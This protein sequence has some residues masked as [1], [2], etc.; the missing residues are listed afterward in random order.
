MLLR[1]EVTADGKSRFCRKDA[2]GTGKWAQDRAAGASD[3]TTAAARLPR[4]LG[5]R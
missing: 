1:A 4:F 2:A 5:A 3:E